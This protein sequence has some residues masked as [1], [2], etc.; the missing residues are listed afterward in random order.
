MADFA[1]RAVDGYNSGDFRSRSTMVST[2][3]IPM[4]KNS[5]SHGF[6]GKISAH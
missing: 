5:D 1:Q 2:T 4:E 3:I 6:R